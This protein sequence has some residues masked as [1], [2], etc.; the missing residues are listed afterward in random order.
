MKVSEPAPGSFKC[1]CGKWWTGSGRC[2]CSGCHMLFSSESAFSK[3][4]TGRADNRQCNMPQEVGLV[5]SAKPYGLLWSFP[6]N[7]EPEAD[8]E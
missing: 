5:M 4:R 6:D 1:K 3:H 2:H 8:D 7:R